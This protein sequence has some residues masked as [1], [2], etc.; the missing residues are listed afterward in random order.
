M[1][2]STSLWNKNEL[3][4]QRINEKM[5]ISNSEVIE[6]EPMQVRDAFSLSCVKNRFFDAAVK[7]VK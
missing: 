3:I 6:M 2:N 7:T 4:G 1:K 5:S